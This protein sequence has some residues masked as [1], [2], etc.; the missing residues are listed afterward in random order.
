MESSESI[1]QR[2]ER[3]RLEALEA[4]SIAQVERIAQARGG[5]LD[6][7]LAILLKHLPALQAQGVS[8]LRIDGIE[9]QLRALPGLELPQG[10]PEPQGRDPVMYGLPP[11]IK[12]PSLRDKR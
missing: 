1:D 3:K 4:Q 11:G 6:E 8:S 9:L 10:P 5:A 2:L 12:L 7:K